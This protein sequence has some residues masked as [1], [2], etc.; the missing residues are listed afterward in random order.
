MKKFKVCLAVLM[1]AMMMGG[2]AWAFDATNHVKVAPNGKG[3]LLIFPWY[4]AYQ[5]GY[6]TK[7]TV[8][9]TSNTQSVV[10]K[11][12][13]RSFNWS[14]EVLDH[15]IFLSPN[16]VWTGTLVN[17]LVNGVNVAKLK[18]NDDSI[19]G[20]GRWPSGAATDADFGNI[21]P[22]DE[23]LRPS[24]C[25]A[26]AAP[27]AGYAD[28]AN[29]FGYIE[30]IEA[31]ARTE[32]VAGTGY[33][34][35]DRV[36]KKHIYDWYVTLADPVKILSYPTAN[37]LTGYQ[38]NTFGVG[39]TLRQANVFADYRNF[40]YLD[41][42]AWTGLGLNANNTL[43]EVE[44]AMGKLN[45]ALP[46]IARANGDTSVHI[47]NFPTKL[48]W[49]NGSTCTN[50]RIYPESPYWMLVNNKCEGYTR[51]IYDLSENTPT[52][53][54]SPFSPYTNPTYYMCGEVQFDQQALG[55]LTYTEGWIRY[56]W[57]KSAVVKTGRQLSGGAISYT[58]TP[59][60]TSALFWTA[61]RANPAEAN[62]AYD[63][64]AVQG[65]RYY[66]YSN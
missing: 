61:A 13:Y 24:R 10:A 1:I 2:S 51:L 5:G 12:I 41:P 55:L 57:S 25:P 34:P 65:L 43:A 28:D 48:S 40:A 47:F 42:G 46:Y 49:E 64:G 19:L 52:D 35:G 45:V 53:A 29:T 7:I 11:V 33:K 62:A 27:P 44:A 16:D 59:V 26:L 58:G 14:F 4:F 56:N 39:Q 21:T 30:V 8:T 9:N 31:A 6:Q 20:S 60:L 15:L 36:A 38:E 66:Q 22:V 3:D 32:S 18:S 37:V 50:Y 17:E 23:V 63:D 54:R